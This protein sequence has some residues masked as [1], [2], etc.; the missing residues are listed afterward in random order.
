[1]IQNINYTKKSCESLIILLEVKL[2]ADYLSLR[3]NRSDFYIWFENTNKH[4]LEVYELNKIDNTF[5]FYFNDISDEFLKRKLKLSVSTRVHRL[6]YLIYNQLSK[7]LL[8]ENVEILLE[9]NTNELTCTINKNDDNIKASKS[10]KYINDDIIDS[11]STIIGQQV[12]SS[13]ISDCPLKIAVIGT[14]FSRSIFRSD[15][16]FNPSYKKYF[17]VPLTVFHSSFISLMSQEL[18]DQEYL[19]A[20]D[21]LPDHIFRYI[22][23]EFQKNIKERL[24]LAG[25][26]YLIIDNYPDATHSVVEMSNDN[27]LT[28][29]RYFAESIY[30]R[31]FSGKN[32]LTPGSKK[33]I[34]QYRESVK[35]LHEVLHTINL[36]KK[37][38][39]LGCRLSAFKSNTELWQSKMDWI[40][41]VNS[42]LDIYD[43]LFL[44]EFPYAQ[45]IDM[46]TTNWISDVNT[47]IVGG[48]SPSHYQSGFYKEL[49][50]KIKNIIFKD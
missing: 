13:N 10:I 3:F 35:K 36:D 2:C 27:M 42:N 37:I 15:E 17:T 29:N 11:R 5:I 12:Y 39:L 45:Y 34:T 46:R 8:K 23:I 31:K 18:V 6:N 14:C 47:P 48:A 44:E 50:E 1:M 16:Y 9:I 4:I 22:T 24:S 38:I 43:S 28:Y 41:K 30:K 21:L 33:H 32:I 26:G 19:F 25:V 7:Y 49:Y 40:N 20:E